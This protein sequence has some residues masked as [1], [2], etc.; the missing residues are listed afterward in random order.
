MDAETEQRTQLAV[1]DWNALTFCFTH[2]V[3]PVVELTTPELRKFA[4]VFA[5]NVLRV[6]EL[7]RL[8][9]TVWSNALGHER[10]KWAPDDTSPISHPV[11]EFLTKNP[12]GVNWYSDACR[13]I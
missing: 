5:R 11:G 13:A 2:P 6:S 8:P 9:D 7:C 10:H 4:E 3:R 1:K 12:F